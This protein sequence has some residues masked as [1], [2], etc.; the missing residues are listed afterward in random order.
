MEPANARG[1]R[2]VDDSMHGVDAWSPSP[3]PSPH[4]HRDSLPQ[5]FVGSLL[6][7]EYVKPRTSEQAARGSE[8]GKRINKSECADGTTFDPSQRDALSPSDKELL[9]MYRQMARSE[10]V[11][12]DKDQPSTPHARRNQKNV[13]VVNVEPELGPRSPYYDIVQVSSSPAPASLQRSSETIDALNQQDMPA[14]RNRALA[15]DSEEDTLQN[16]GEPLRPP[17]DMSRVPA[18]MI[19]HSYN[20][21]PPSSATQ[22]AEVRV[23]S[24]AEMQEWRD[25]K[26]SSR[27]SSACRPPTI[28]RPVSARQRR[29]PQ[30]ADGELA[31]AI[32]G[33][34]VQ[35]HQVDKSRALQHMLDNEMA[36]KFDNDEHG[37]AHVEAEI[38][39]DDVDDHLADPDH[40]RTEQMRSENYRIHPAPAVAL[41]VRIGSD[42]C[43]V[44]SPRTSPVPSNHAASRP[45]SG[46]SRMDDLLLTL[47]PLAHTPALIAAEQKLEHHE[48]DRPQDEQIGKP[49]HGVERDPP[50][51][52]LDLTSDAQGHDM[53]EHVEATSRTTDNVKPGS[54]EG[55]DSEHKRTPLDATLSSSAQQH[56]ST[57]GFQ[58]SS[59]DEVHQSG[60]KGFVMC[61]AC[62]TAVALGTDQVLQQ[63][64]LVLRYFH[65]NPETPTPTS[66]RPPSSLDR[67][68]EVQKVV[69]LSRAHDLSQC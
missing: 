22:P 11:P 10:E 34:L 39:D 66:S 69:Y 65:E 47:P 40:Q 20:R 60:R 29:Q 24:L 67:V 19:I 32:A 23:E 49:E 27:P 62:K 15:K 41:G 13:N 45:T 7:P 21:K 55:A 30:E 14:P 31:S 17:V 59:E 42:T 4:L 5:L 46:T 37:L 6:L 26:S 61:P 53:V 28:S 2:P 33:I 12:V 38:Y 58:T 16:G 3:N 36:N 35:G 50:A 1:S 8:S 64:Q 48:L 56:I 57:A 9:S 18:P 25:K 44:M 68:P 63:Q 52:T 43:S 51:Q 54:A